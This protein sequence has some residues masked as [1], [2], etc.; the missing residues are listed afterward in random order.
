MI[1]FVFI[2]QVPWWNSQIISL[3]DKIAINIEYFPKSSNDYFDDYKV[4][5]GTAEQARG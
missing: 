4:T 1:Q 2:M 5:T 3:H